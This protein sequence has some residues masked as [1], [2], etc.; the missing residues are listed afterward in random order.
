M[1]AL[2]KDEAKKILSDNGYTDLSTKEVL[3]IIH[4][5]LQGNIDKLHG[6]IKCI[7]KNQARQVEKCSQQLQRYASFTSKN[8]MVIKN[9]EASLPDKGFCE[10][11]NASLEINGNNQ[12]QLKIKVDT[13]WNDRK[14]IKGMAG[15]LVAIFIATVSILIQN[16]F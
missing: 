4:Q 3:A 15:G 7:K 8:N 13:L 9:L 10:I 2:D 12:S 1:F 14:W 5:A 6:D 16:L 11:V